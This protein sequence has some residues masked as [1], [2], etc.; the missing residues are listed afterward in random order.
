ML[1]IGV[2]N[3]VWCD[4]SDA[5]FGAS[6]G[7]HL[8]ILAGNMVC[9][10]FGHKEVF[11]N[12]SSRLDE[13]IAQSIKLGCSVF[14]TGAMGEFDSMFSS[15]VRK[16]KR[17]N[18]GIK[19]ICVKPYMTKEINENKDFY[20]SM[21]DDVII[22]SELMGVHYKGAIK[23]RNRWIVD[24]SEIVIGYT[25]RDYGGAHTA[26]KYAERLKKKMIYI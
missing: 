21:Y 6:F 20:A 22:P 10:G 13:A 17:D 1:F 7:S 16:A 2:V 11:Q 23:A 9:C 25:I 26:I 24:N 15:A 4:R 19:L 8:F 12:I 18:P 14:Y 5:F 3:V